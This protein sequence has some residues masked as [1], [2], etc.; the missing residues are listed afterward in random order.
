MNKSVR[1]LK[2]LL[3]IRIQAISTLFFYKQNTLPSYD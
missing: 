1:R 3:A 2:T